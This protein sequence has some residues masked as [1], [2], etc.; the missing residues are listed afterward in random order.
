MLNFPMMWSTWYDFDLVSEDMASIHRKFIHA[1]FIVQNIL[2][3]LTRYANSIGYLIYSLSP[4][5]YH[6]MVNMIN[7]FF[8][9][10]K[11]RMSRPWVI[12]KILP[13]PPKFS[14]SLLKKLEHHALI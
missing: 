4:V 12:F 3:S 8:G 14:S 5:I 1:K 9:G 2:N 10:D 11:C 6:Y 7:V 13:S